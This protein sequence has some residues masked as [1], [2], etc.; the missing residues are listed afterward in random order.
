VLRHQA[1]AGVTERVGKGRAQFP[2]LDE[3]AGHR[4]AGNVRVAEQRSRVVERTQRHVKGGEL[5]GRAGVRVHDGADIRAAL[6]DLGVDVV[7]DV[8]RAAA[9]EDIAVRADQDD[10]A[11]VDLLESPA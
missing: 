11:G 2:V 7:L 1:G 8:P 5:V 6:H 10:L 3:A 4:E 9:L